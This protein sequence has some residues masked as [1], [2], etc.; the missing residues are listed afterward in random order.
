MKKKGLR[1][2][3]A[4]IKEMRE[5]LDKARRYLL[6]KEQVRN[7]VYTCMT[8]LVVNIVHQHLIV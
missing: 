2:K 5:Q 6:D 7:E 3:D 8:V 4:V 1:E